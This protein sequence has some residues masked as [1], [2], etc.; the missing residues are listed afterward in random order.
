MQGFD[1]ANQGHA[2]TA[3]HFM[4]VDQLLA[5][6]SAALDAQGALVAPHLDIL[7]KGSR[8]MRMERVVQ[9]LLE[10]AKTCS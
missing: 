7:I 3:S 2:A 4:N 6:L 8:F 9:A 10:E 5:E 1:K